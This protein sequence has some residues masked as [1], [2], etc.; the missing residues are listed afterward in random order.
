MIQ[1]TKNGK[2]IQNVSE[3]TLTYPSLNE[4]NYVAFAEV[5]EEY[6]NELYGFLEFKEY[7]QEYKNNK[8]T[9]PYI[10]KKKQKTYQFTLTEYIR[11]QI[12]HPENDLNE[13]YIIRG[14]GQKILTISIQ[15][16]DEDEY[17][18]DED[19]SGED[20]E[21]EE[22]EEGEGEDEEGYEGESGEGED[23]E[24]EDEDEEGEDGEDE[25]EDED[26][27]EGDMDESKKHKSKKGMKHMKCMKCMKESFKY[28]FMK[29]KKGK[30]GKKDKKVGKKSEGDVAADGSIDAMVKK[31]V[32][33]G[34]PE[35]FA[36]VIAKKKAEKAKNESSWMNDIFGGDPNKKNYD[37]I[38]EMVEQNPMVLKKSLQDA[39][40]VAEKGGN[41]ALLSIINKIKPHVLAGEKI[42]QN[43]YDAIVDGNPNEILPAYQAASKSGKF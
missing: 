30:K 28:N 26:E 1:N 2:I 15:L 14:D 35:K 34:M 32:K 17:E 10:H 4:I 12:H 31:L 6:H 42:D 22:E 9:K 25:D 24:G 41:T 40:F 7:L 8:E 11:H 39:E 13:K 37:G 29:G 21:E 16:S 23:E 18:G 38:N 33:K 3:S 5:T 20:E 43:L 27:D 36:M 19:E